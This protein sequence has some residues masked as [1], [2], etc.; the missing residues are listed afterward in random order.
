MWGD[1]LHIVLV[2]FQTASRDEG[3]TYACRAVTGYATDQAQ[4]AIGAYR[5]TPHPICS[6]RQINECRLIQ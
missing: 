5:Y 4:S 3:R 2:S 1:Y 6:R